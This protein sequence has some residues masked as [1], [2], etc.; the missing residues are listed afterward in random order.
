VPLNHFRDSLK[1]LVKLLTTD[2]EL[3]SGGAMRITVMRFLA[4]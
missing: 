4:A 2:D 1:D 3:M